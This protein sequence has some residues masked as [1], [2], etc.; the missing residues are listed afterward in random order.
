MLRITPLFTLILLSSCVPTYSN[1]HFAK[2]HNLTIQKASNINLFNG[3][4]QIENNS[5][6]KD[7]NPVY[8]FYSG[9]TLEYISNDTRVPD[10]KFIYK[11]YPVKDSF[12]LLTK[13]AMF[14]RYYTVDTLLFRKDFAI[15]KMTYY[16]GA[17][18]VHTDLRIYQ[19]SGDKLTVTSYNPRN[20]VTPVFQYN[21]EMNVDYN[22][23]P[24]DT[25][26]Y[27]TQNRNSFFKKHVR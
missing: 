10:N 4:I 18:I 16:Q 9:A 27:S 14:P 17:E 1:R 2:T 6:E 26:Y 8:L 22:W 19:F 20:E 23:R 11:V 21:P 24:S 15:H 7:K 3:S 13:A 12:T 5:D 25:Q